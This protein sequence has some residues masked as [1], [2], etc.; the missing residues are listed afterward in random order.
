MMTKP[1]LRHRS[2]QLSLALVLVL[3]LLSSCTQNLFVTKNKLP[4][5]STLDV[6]PGYHYHLRKDDKISLSVW[7]HEALSVGSIY[8]H[9][10][11]R[12]TVFGLYTNPETALTLLG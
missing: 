1:L 10:K 11:V 4:A 5:A 9:Y 6:G 8:G 3:G 12:A 2:R 7:D